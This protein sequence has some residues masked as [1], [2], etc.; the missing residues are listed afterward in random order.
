MKG[1][2]SNVAGW[3]PLRGVGKLAGG[4]DRIE[5]HRCHG[6]VTPVAG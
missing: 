4:I 1:F 5:F 3:L 6:S 2:K